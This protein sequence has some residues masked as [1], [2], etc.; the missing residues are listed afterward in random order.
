MEKQQHL[1]SVVDCQSQLI[2]ESFCDR[3]TQLFYLLVAR[4]NIFTIRD[5]LTCPKCGG[6]LRII[7]FIDNPGVIEMIL[8]HL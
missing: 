6:S 8:K 4:L 5:P 2:K 3:Q 7:S 1:E